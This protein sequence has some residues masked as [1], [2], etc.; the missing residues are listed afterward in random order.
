MQTN[1]LK[2]FTKNE[3]EKEMNSQNSNM[4]KISDILED[5]FLTLKIQEKQQKAA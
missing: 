3:G 4:R 2:N 5:R 1:I